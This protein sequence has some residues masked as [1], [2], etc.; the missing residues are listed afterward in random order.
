MFHF[1]DC[2]RQTL[3]T[4]RDMSFHIPH[5]IFRYDYIKY[6]SIIKCLILKPLEKLNLPPVESKSGYGPVSYVRFPARYE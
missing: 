4:G 1:M 6:D 5:I 2:F 3:A